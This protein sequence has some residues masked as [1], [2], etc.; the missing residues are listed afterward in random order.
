MNVV[1]AKVS[2]D[3]VAFADVSLPIPDGRDLSGY[4]GRTV[5]VGIRPSDLEDADV[6][7]RDGSPVIEVVPDVVEELGTEVHVL[8]TIDAPPVVTEQTEAASA[9]EEDEALAPLGDGRATFTATVDAR[10]KARVGEPVR[11]AVDPARLYFFDPT[12]GQALGRRSAVPAAGN[13]A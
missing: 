10:S 13:R 8:F 9:V 5:I 1:E 4:A 12:S 3:G 7:H 2:N 6:W 11:L